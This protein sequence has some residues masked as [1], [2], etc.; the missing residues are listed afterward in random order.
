M[1]KKNNLRLLTSAALVGVLAVFGAPNAAQAKNTCD[2]TCY[3]QIVSNCASE[4]NSEANWWRIGGNFQTCVA[5]AASQC[6][7]TFRQLH[8]SM[9]SAFQMDFEPTGSNEN[10]I[11][12]GNTGQ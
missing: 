7:A 11:V 5:F 6:N 12:V 3:N 2:F 4:N 8:Q 1:Y 9:G 10:C